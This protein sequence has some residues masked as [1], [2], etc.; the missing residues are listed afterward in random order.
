MLIVED[1]ITTGKSSI[2]CPKLITAADANVLGFACL[3]DRSNGASKLN[4]KIVSQVQINIPTYKA[5]NLPK[6]LKFL[7]TTKPGSRNI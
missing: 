5:D 1:V 4:K 7:P 3:I 2:E 6:N